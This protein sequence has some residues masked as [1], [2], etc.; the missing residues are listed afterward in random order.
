MANKIFKEMLSPQTHLTRNGFDRSHLHNF[1]AKIGELLPVMTLETVPGSHYEIRVSDLMRS[2]PMNSAAFVR[3]NQH[4]EFYFVPYKQ[5]WRKWDDFFTGRGVPVSAGD[6]LNVP[7]RAPRFSSMY[8]VMADC[9]ASRSV[10]AAN[11]GDIGEFIGAGCDK[12]AGL[13]GYPNNKMF[14]DNLFGVA[15]QD[16]ELKERLQEIKPNAFRAAAYQKICFDYYRQPFYDLPKFYTSWT[17]N[18]DDANISTGFIADEVPDPDTGVGAYRYA[19]LFQMHYRQW[20]K[21]LFTGVLPDTQFGAVAVVSTGGSD[22]ATI[23]QQVNLAVSAI[24][25]ANT[26]VYGNQAVAFARNSTSYISGNL[27]ANKNESIGVNSILDTKV[28]VEAGTGP[29]VGF[30]NDFPSEISPRIIAQGNTIMDNITGSATGTIDIPSGGTGSFDVLSLCRAQALQRWREITM[31]SGFRNVNQYEGHFGVRPIYTEKDR[32]V[33]IDSFTSPFQVNSVLN[34][35]AGA[36]IDGKTV[37][38]GDMA[39][40]GTSVINSDKTI[41]FDAKDFGVIMCIYSMLPEATYNDFGIEIMNQKSTKEEFF[42]PEFENIGMQPVSMDH[43]Q[44]SGGD[45]M[46]NGYAARY[47]E[48]KVGID[49]Q[50]IEFASK[51]NYTHGVHTNAGRF[52]G[53]SPSRTFSVDWQTSGIISPAIFARDLYVNPTYYKEIFSNLP[54]ATDSENVYAPQ[55]TIGDSAFDS[56]MHQCY[57]DIK[58]VQPMSVLGLPSY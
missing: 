22:S 34:T 29:Y 8:D 16:T 3:A 24:G 35:N 36:Q 54:Y 14:V 21:D 53:W 38:L 43:F 46:I 7:A 27:I 20:K 50:S 17:F 12:I 37:A 42:T 49:R 2:I 56:F 10:D 18:L 44:V 1:T 32:C 48:Y 25:S 15:Q 52:A 28:D 9:Y 57:F 31:R 26:T 55:Q 58:C 11:L 39:A 40:N 45:S 30:A 5:L 4:F 41:K 51:Y 19:R 33:F 23:Q 47:Y 13:L 6:S